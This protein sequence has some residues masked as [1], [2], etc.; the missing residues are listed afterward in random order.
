MSRQICF[1]SGDRTKNGLV[2]A[3]ATGQSLGMLGGGE[4]RC[5]AV[6]L[7]RTLENSYRSRDELGGI[8]GDRVRA[9]DSVGELERSRVVSSSVAPGILLSTFT[10]SDA[11]ST[12]PSSERLSTDGAI[13]LAGVRASSRASLAETVESGESLQAETRTSSGGQVRVEI[14]SAIEVGRLLL[15]VGIGGG[16]RKEESRHRIEPGARS[17]QTQS[18][19]IAKERKM[20]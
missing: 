16:S 2:G 15:G 9:H 11:K 18:L 3:V 10:G 6:R 13:V 7:T 14:T 5:W 8:T 1:R 17:E 12:V 20:R 4:S 19:N